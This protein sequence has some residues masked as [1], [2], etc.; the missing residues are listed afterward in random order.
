MVAGIFSA[1]HPLPS[2]HSPKNMAA[3]ALNVPTPATNQPYYANNLQDMMANA[4][5]NYALPA[6]DHRTTTAHNATQWKVWT[7][8]CP[9]M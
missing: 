9:Y 4:L 5:K 8:Q 6:P 7:T 2:A 3:D 1:Q